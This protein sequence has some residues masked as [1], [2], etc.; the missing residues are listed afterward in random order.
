MG[1][2]A[3]SKYIY[4]TF[5]LGT[6]SSRFPTK[7]EIVNL[8]LTVSGS[9]ANNQLVQESHISNPQ[10]SYEDVYLQFAWNWYAY[11]FPSQ[12]SPYIG[13]DYDQASVT[14][15]AIADMF[16][17][18]Y[19]GQ[20]VTQSDQEY[21]YNQYNFN[22]YLTYSVPEGTISSQIEGEPVHVSLTIQINPNQ[23]SADFKIEI[24]QIYGYGSGEEVLLHTIQSNGEQAGWTDTIDITLTMEWDAQDDFYIGFKPVKV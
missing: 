9:Y 19:Y 3:T 12:G 24:Y 23:F 8:G 16:G 1:K 14:Y 10:I 15:A 6:S 18:Q 13:T 5:S 20:T 11:E 7:S 4:D 21:A 2:L 17:I 22:S